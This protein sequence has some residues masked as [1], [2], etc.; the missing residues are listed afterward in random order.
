MASCVPY[1]TWL[2][3]TQD[4]R[5]MTA[6]VKGFGYAPTGRLGLAALG[7]GELNVS[8]AASDPCAI[9]QQT[10]CPQPAPPSL[11]APPTAQQA[12]A[13]NPSSPP[14]LPGG[15]LFCKI[16]PNDY[17]CLTPLLTT[18]DTLTP[19]PSAAS[20]A[21]GFNQWGLLAALAV[22]GTAIY[23]L[24]RKKKPQAS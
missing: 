4:C 2:K 10:P 16:H 20:T 7:L 11:K 9:A 15:A 13:N 1:A 8:S 6:S 21:G 23:F 5:A 3:A 14:C 18:S 24:T 22:G 17:N 12:C 19:D